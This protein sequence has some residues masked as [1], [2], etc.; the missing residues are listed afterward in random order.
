MG[1]FGIVSRVS[2]R[3]CWVR[4]RYLIRGVAARSEWDRW[5]E[6]RVVSGSI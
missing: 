1:E 2:L 6:F 3:Y 4:V 5:V